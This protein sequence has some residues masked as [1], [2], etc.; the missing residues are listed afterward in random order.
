MMSELKSQWLT[1]VNKAKWGK[2]AFNSFV[3]PKIL[4]LKKVRQSWRNHTTLC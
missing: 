3:H 2:K 1:G 4:S